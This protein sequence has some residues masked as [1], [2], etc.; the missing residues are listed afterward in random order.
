[1]IWQSSDRCQPD[2][3]LYT[4]CTGD[5]IF[6][7]EVW[8]S[9]YQSLYPQEFRWS[10][11]PQGY[12]TSLP[13]TTYLDTQASDPAGEVSFTVGTLDGDQLSPYTWYYANI[14]AQ[15]D[16]PGPNYMKLRVQTGID[17]AWGCGIVVTP[18][19]CML[20]PHNGFTRIDFTAHQTM[21]GY[22][23]YGP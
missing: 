6:E 10:S 12:S 22:V 20:D 21:P 2:S 8:L 9:N 14:I 15:P 23:S 18:D 5:T 3:K 13:G 11:Y 1:M 7:H 16:W 17:D 19:W 4:F